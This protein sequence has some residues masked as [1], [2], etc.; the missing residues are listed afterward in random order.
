MKKYPNV[1]KR[2]I[3]QIREL[4][5][6]LLVERFWHRKKILSS[7]P[8]ICPP[9]SDLEVHMQIC[10]RDWQNAPWTIASFAYFAKQPFRLV[11]LH[12]GSV[13]E[14][15]WNHLKRLYPGIVIADRES[16]RGEVEKRFSS[17][18]PTILKMWE[19]GYYCTLPK[20]VD[21]WILARNKTILTIDPDVLFFDYPDE[22]LD[23]SLV[24]GE[25]GI[26]NYC[27]TGGDGRTSHYCLNVEQLEKDMNI[28]LPYHFGIGLGRVNL[29]YCDWELCEKVLSKHFPQGRVKHFM[30]DQTI[31]GLWAAEH[32]FSM[33][34]RDRY[35]V[36]PVGNLDGVVARHYYSKT[37]DLMY[38]EGIRTLRK[39]SG[40]LKR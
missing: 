22:L 38:V 7:A 6:G 29:E 27:N 19:S 30:I 26:L 2:G 4:G 28:R 32:G 35:A 37:R 18:S 15:G 9:D 8:L 10:K 17:L 12:D 36:N 20:V 21:S 14:F 16:L 24:K 13:P 23:A 31:M 39:K 40:F 3:S 5:L 25:L 34:D 33:L 1:I 11:M